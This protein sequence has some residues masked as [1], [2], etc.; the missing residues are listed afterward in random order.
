[1][2]KS[3][4]KTIEEMEEYFK[5]CRKIKFKD[6][7]N[8]K[9]LND[10]FVNL[11]GTHGTGDYKDNSVSTF[12][13]KGSIHCEVSNN[14]GGKKYRSINDF[15]LISK[16]YF[17]EKP[18][19]EII[20]FLDSKEKEHNKEE[21]RGLMVAYCSQVRRY[22][23]RGVGNNRYYKKLKDYNIDDIFPNLDKKVEEIISL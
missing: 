9:S 1:M 12:Y 23:I 7:V 16:K 21:G 14:W 17:P 22:N 15:L 6:D 13:N 3:D 20:K 10:V 11:F 2:K 18:A 5:K 19:T 8:I 4:V